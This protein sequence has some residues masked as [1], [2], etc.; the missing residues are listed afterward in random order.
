M[1]LSRVKNQFE[2]A[3]SFIESCRNMTEMKELKHELNSLTSRIGFRWYALT[4]VAAASKGEHRAIRLTN[5]PDT[6]RKIYDARGFHRNDPVV[7]AL[8]N[9]ALPITWDQISTS[10]TVTKVQVEILHAAADHGLRY[11][12]SVPV[13]IPGEHQGLVSFASDDENALSTESFALASVIAPVAFETARRIT[14]R[15]NG[16]RGKTTPSLTP[17]QKECLVL[18]AQGKSDWEAGQ[19]LGLSAQTVHGH[20]EA[21]RA[22][23]GVRRRTQLIV[24]ALFCG[25][26]TFRE[27]L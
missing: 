4:R 11:G 25:Q 14:A 22:R 24:Q 9:T 18:I 26:I 13:R 8:E 15:R 19:I 12:I 1:D 3:V 21:V 7:L 6:W 16:S 10:S 20:V 17:R 27:I 2:I 5:Y 23:Y